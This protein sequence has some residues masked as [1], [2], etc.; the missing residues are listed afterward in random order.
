MWS[1]LICFLIA[2]C[3]LFSSVY[4][5][6]LSRIKNS[7]DISSKSE[8]LTNIKLDEREFNQIDN[9]IINQ[10]SELN[11]IKAAKVSSNQINEL[12]DELRK[13]K[14]RIVSDPI[15]LDQG[16]LE[17]DFFKIKDG[18]SRLIDEELIVEPKEEKTSYEPER[19]NP[20]LPSLPNEVQSEDFL[21][22]GPVIPIKTKFCKTDQ[23]RSANQTNPNYYYVDCKS[24]N[25]DYKCFYC[26]KEHVYLKS[27]SKC[28]GPCKGDECAKLKLK[29]L[30]VYCPTDY[31]DDESF[32]R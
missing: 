3:L 9:K 1:S 29:N 25:K 21:H 6:D 10:L 11:Q 23:C 16:R 17:D 7:V 24:E 13:Q 30:H 20:D 12:N 26:P 27:K 4:S 8:N 22:S 18:E 5:I 31:V 28:V 2:N 32:L 15:S 14:L 19:T